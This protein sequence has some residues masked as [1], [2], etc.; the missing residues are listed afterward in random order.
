MVDAARTFESHVSGESERSYLLNLVMISIG[1]F[2]LILGAQ[3]MVF[4]AVNIARGVGVSEL[5]IGLTIVAIGTSLP[6]LATAVL[7][8][9][10]KESEIVIGN[11]AGS[12][13]FNISA[14]LALVALICPIPISNH[15]LQTEL[16]ILI[17]FTAFLLPLALCLRRVPGWAGYVYLI[18]FS[19][20]LIWQVSQG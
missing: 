9:R 12:N 20:F 18:A 7:A 6:E 19:A 13:L 11:V 1:L 8:S 15:S 3:L 10:K 17:V 2:A 14:I 4:G 5:T 16:P